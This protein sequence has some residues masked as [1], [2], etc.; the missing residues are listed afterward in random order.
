MADS[1]VL[2]LHEQPKDC[3]W[4]VVDSDGRQTERRR[5]GAL[6][7]VHPTATGRRLIVL[8]P[9]S[10]VITTRVELPQVSKARQRQMLPFALEDQFAVDVATL[11]FAP[12][13]RNEDDQLYVSVVAHELLKGWLERLTAANLE[14]AAIYADTDGVADTPA[15]LNVIYENGAIFAR[16]P[17]DAALSIEGLDLADA[18][19]IIAGE[20]D[21][22]TTVQHALLC[23]DAEAHQANAAQIEALSSQFAGLDVKLLQEDALPLFAAKLINHPGANLLQG[24]YAP[25]S[26]W[27]A[28]MKPWRVAAVLGAALVATAL[29]GTVIDYIQLQRNDSA[30]TEA[31]QVRCTEE[32]RTPDL[33]QCEAAVRQRLGAVNAGEGGSED[34]LATLASVA[35]TTIE[36]NTLR[37]VSFRNSVMDMQIVTPDVPALDAFS[38]RLD[39]SGPYTVSVQSTNPQ[40]DGTVESRIQIVG[41]NR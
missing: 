21:D 35:E 26:N 24:T 25:K 15:T 39:E 23:I 36:A 9:G 8:V 29:L 22:E 3:E 30:L 20:P 17:G 41:A 14:P 1:V 10:D 2:R 6:S 40:E 18:F 27:G 38:R 11:H 34:F 7:E 4:V 31:L 19:S 12:G 16:R 33:R 32:F 5:S 13:P 37:S 28:M